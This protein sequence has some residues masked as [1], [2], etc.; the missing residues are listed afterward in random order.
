MIYGFSLLLI[1]L[2]LVMGIPAIRQL[3]NMQNIQ[4]NSAIT[5]GRVSSSKNLLG[6]GTWTAALGNQ[7]RPL[8]QYYLPSGAELVLEVNTNSIF[9]K[10]RY[11][12]GRALE[13]TY[14]SAHPSRAYVTQEWTVALRELWMSSGA[15]VIGVVFCII[16]RVYNLPFKKTQCMSQLL[17]Q[18]ELKSRHHLQ[19]EFG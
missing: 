14:D 19:L 11:E 18:C 12:V 3:L 4:K 16:G 1:V 9:P 13:V 8:I 2:G 6:N 7:D 5:R 10:R 17:L 15:L